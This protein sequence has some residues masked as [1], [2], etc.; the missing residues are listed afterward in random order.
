M[1]GILVVLGTGAIYFIFIVQNFYLVD[2][3]LAQMRTY[4][5]TL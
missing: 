3:T 5:E 2:R 1:G 4:T